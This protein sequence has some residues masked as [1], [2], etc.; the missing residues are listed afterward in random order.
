MLEARG[1][2][3]RYGGVAALREAELVLRPGSAHALLGENGAGKSTLVKVIAGAVRPDAGVLRLD[4]EEV[5]FS[6]TAD[7][8]EHGV[9][10]VSQELNLFPDLDILAN[11]FPMREPRRGPFVDRAAMASRAR[12]V[13]AELGLGVSLRQPLSSL[14][15]GSRQL[16]EI[17]KAL[18]CDPKVLILDEPTSA[19][20]QDSTEA[21]MAALRVLR[22]RDV[23]VLFVTHILEE[24]MALCDEFTVLRD[25]E[26]VLAG[27][28][29][30]EVTVTSLVRAML[31][32]RYQGSAA[33][34]A[35][36][37]DDEVKAALHASAAGNHSDGRLRVE[38]VSIRGRLQDVTFEARPGEILGL[39]GVAGSGPL[40]VLELLSGTRSPERGRVWLPHNRPLPRG[41]RQCI[42]A[43]VALVSGDRRRVGL[44][45]DKPIWENVAEVRAFALAREGFLVRRRGLRQR[46]MAHMR[47]LGIRARSPDHRADALSGGNQQKVVFAK[48][49]E[50]EPSVLLL[51]DPTRGVDVGTK[52]EMHRLIRSLAAARG[53]VILCSTDLDELARLCD[54]VLVFY[55]HR[56]C[57]EL[58]GGQLSQPVILETMNTGCL[59]QAA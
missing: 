9:G 7:A 8:A 34:E 28:P 36:G 39:A 13:L 41:Q 5:S 21:L 6:S 12:P 52:A 24:A 22:S 31:G 42:G 33:A 47:Q 50:A 49:L 45:L 55:Q 15:L 30:P 51:D 19:L 20:H 58:S 10:I 2:S 37:I 40:S 46:A 54:R 1:I 4:G 18:L 3:K 53:V 27:R 11:L 29:R 48:W 35:I 25:G 23:A 16:V 32:E 26:V 56:V 14:D 17:A 59:G 43:G 44:M 57:A 38:G